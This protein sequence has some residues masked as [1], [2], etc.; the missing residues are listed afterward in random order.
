MWIF[1]PTLGNTN[2]LMTSFS[3]HFSYN[4]QLYHRKSEVTC[5][6][7]LEYIFHSSKT[8]PWPDSIWGPHAW[9]VSVLSIRP[10]QFLRNWGFCWLFVQSQSPCKLKTWRLPVILRMP[11]DLQQ[12][13]TCI[14]QISLWIIMLSSFDMFISLMILWIEWLLQFSANLLNIRLPMLCRKLNTKLWKSSESSV[15]RYLS[16]ENWVSTEEFRK[17]NEST[18]LG[19]AVLTEIAPLLTKRF[20]RA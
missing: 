19:F 12:Q 2:S 13:V 11:Y 15:F 5:S 17:N 14:L 9:E 18:R 10:F 1:P 6:I 8:C 20:L 7:I 16:A 3:F 4:S